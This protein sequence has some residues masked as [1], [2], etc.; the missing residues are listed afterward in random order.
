V[1]SILTRETFRFL[2][3]LSRHNRTEWMRANR[4]RYDEHVVAAMRRLL[5]A[6]AP[7]ALS[8][9]PGFD[10]AGRVGGNF[11]RINRD[12]R[13]AKDKRPYRPQLY[14]QFS[15][16]ER[17]G[18][19]GQLYVGVGAEAVTAGFRI[20]GGGRDS[21]LRQVARANALENPA[22]LARQARR[23]GRRYESYWYANIKG[24]WSKQDGF[25]TKAEQWERLQ[26]WIVRRSFSAA[27]ATRARFPEDVAKVFK[28]LFPLYAFSSLAR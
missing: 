14:L 23:L 9:H 3:D 4:A 8:F 12:T 1:P 7:L 25:P 13:F 18:D 26:G 21:T 2:R 5:D 20:Y 27:A 16:A 24:R 19:D 17:R 22:W 28:D 11:S 10:T 15:R 6:L